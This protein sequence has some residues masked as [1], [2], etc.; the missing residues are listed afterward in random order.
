MAPVQFRESARIEVLDIDTLDGVG[1][2]HVLHL[3]IAR[4]FLHVFAL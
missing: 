4:G 2:D 1:I 3:R